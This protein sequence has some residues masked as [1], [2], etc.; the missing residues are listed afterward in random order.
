MN[1]PLSSTLISHK[2]EL[3]TYSPPG[4][5]GTA[6]VRLFD[7][8]FCPAFEMILGTIEPGGIADKHHHETE[9]QAMYVLAGV[10]EVTLDDEI[11]VS[12]GPGAVIRLPPKVP[13][14]VVSKGPDPLQLLIVY[15]PPLPRRD[16]KPLGKQ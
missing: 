16:D 5:A 8:S 2:D 4:H 9:H 1:S 10:A 14:H 3:D 15:S 7:K 12:C 6:N 13:H 11:P